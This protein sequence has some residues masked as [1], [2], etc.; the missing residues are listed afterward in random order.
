MQNP[1]SLLAL[2]VDIEQQDYDKKPDM[3]VGWYN[4]YKNS[5]KIALGIE[6]DSLKVDLDAEKDAFRSV[7]VDE[8][9]VEALDASRFPKWWNVLERATLVAVLTFSITVGHGGS[10]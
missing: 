2:T 8:F 1:R 5:D 4:T 7:E 6:I 10:I 9:Q 3:V